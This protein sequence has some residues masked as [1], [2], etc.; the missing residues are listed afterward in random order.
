MRIL[1]D[2]AIHAEAIK[3]FVSQEEMLSRHSVNSKEH[4]V[5][6]LEKFYSSPVSRRLGNAV[7]GRKPSKVIELVFSPKSSITM[8]DLNSYLNS[9]QLFKGRAEPVASISVV[10]IPSKHS[11]NIMVRSSAGKA[12]AVCNPAHRKYTP[13]NV[14]LEVYLIHILSLFRAM[15]KKFA[16]VKTLP[17]SI[18]QKA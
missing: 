7:R 5:S 8:A 11:I 13:S 12:I 9:V 10:Y 1:M 18:L 2:M 4:L 16:V 17:E 3:S 14:T 6:L 15:S